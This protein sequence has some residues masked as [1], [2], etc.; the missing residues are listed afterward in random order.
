M[1]F[2]RVLFRSHIWRVRKDTFSLPRRVDEAPLDPREVERVTTIPHLVNIELGIGLLLLVLLIAWATWVDAPLRDAA[3]PTH[4]P[5]PAKAAWYFMGFQELLLHFHPA[6]VT[7]AIPG[8]VASAV[9][10][11]PYIDFDEETALDVRG[12]WFRSM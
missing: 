6:F 4:P 5:N 10:L 2:R 12:I 7:V 8:L 9:L 3:N 11:L 1:E